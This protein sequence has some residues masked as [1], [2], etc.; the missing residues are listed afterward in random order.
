M[1][2]HRMRFIAR[3]CAVHQTPVPQRHLN[4][5]KQAL[6]STS[7]RFTIVNILQSLL[8]KYDV[9]PHWRCIHLSVT[10]LPMYWV[11]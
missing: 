11:F 9:L 2:A 8:K 1:R 3:P 5:G 4:F 6:R 10:S 7:A